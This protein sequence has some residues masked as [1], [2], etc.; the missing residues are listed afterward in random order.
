MAELIN[1]SQLYIGNLL[2][3][4]KGDEFPSEHNGCAMASG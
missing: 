2:Q 3:T 1:R 4:V